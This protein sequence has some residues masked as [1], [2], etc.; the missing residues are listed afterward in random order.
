MLDI[1]RGSIA[2]FLEEY[3]LTLQTLNRSPKTI[4]WYS[5]ILLSYFDFLELNSMLKPVSEMG[6]PELKACI[7]HLQKTPRWAKRPHFE[8]DKGKPVPPFDTGSCTGPESLLGLAGKGG[9]RPI[10]PWPSSRC[11]RCP[12]S[13]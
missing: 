2:Q 10:T 9:I 7:L 13:R 3:K 8:V 11:P 12:I 1:L 4:S 6:T 5:E